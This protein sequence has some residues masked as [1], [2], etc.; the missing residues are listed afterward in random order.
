MVGRQVGVSDDEVIDVR[1]SAFQ[2]SDG[3]RALLRTIVDRD[4]IDLDEMGRCLGTSDEGVFAVM[5]GIAEKLDEFRYLA[6][7]RTPPL[8]TD[9]ALVTGR[10]PK[11]RRPLKSDSS[12]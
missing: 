6:E 9:V 4:V 11:H 1:T 7:N 12:S 8:G 5:S 3:E 10:R 2:L